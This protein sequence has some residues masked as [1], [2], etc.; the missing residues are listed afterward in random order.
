M[1][2]LSLHIL[3]IAENS[4]SAGATKIEISIRE[5]TRRNTFELEIKDNGRGMDESALKKAADPFFTTRTT[6]KVG[7][8]IPLLSQAA[9]AAEGELTL[10]GMKGQGTRL[11]ARF[12]H[13]HIDR[14]PLGDIGQTITVL[15][16][17]QPDRDFI[18]SHERNG[19]SFRLDTSEIRKTLEDVPLNS[20]DVL[21]FVKDSIMKW[22][23]STKSIIL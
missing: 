13:D 5:D 1:Q 9:K 20:P 15:I 2:D 11:T 12:Q 19:R 10:N 16:A 23:N 6:R 7:L 8:G 3:D 21:N 17:S 4:I 14:K 18:Y 22:L